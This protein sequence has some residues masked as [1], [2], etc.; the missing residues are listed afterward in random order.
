MSRP[1][2]RDAAKA[3]TFG[4][5]PGGA[6]ACVDA[7]AFTGRMQGL[8]T[9]W[10][11]LFCS[12]LVD[13]AQLIGGACQRS[14]GEECDGLSAAFCIAKGNAAPPNAHWLTL[15]CPGS[16]PERP[17]DLFTVVQEGEPI[18]YGTLSWCVYGLVSIVQASSPS[19]GKL[20]GGNVCPRCAIWL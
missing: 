16:G 6:A 1:D 4:I 10:P 17:L 3:L 18:R 11:R 5:V 2:W 7:E 20:A 19:P 9:D 14:I 15:D 8:A 13:A 12:M